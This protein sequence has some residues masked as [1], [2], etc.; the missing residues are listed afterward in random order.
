M[1]EALKKSHNTRTKFHCREVT[2]TS[3]NYKIILYI[4]KNYNQQSCSSH[5]PTPSQGKHHKKGKEKEKERGKEKEES[6][7]E[8]ENEKEEKEKEKM[9]DMEKKREDRESGT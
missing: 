9:G 7:K 8:K 6:G 5:R 3:K 1:V 2:I 4:S